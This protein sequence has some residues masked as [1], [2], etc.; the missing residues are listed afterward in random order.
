MKS[1]HA[2]EMTDL[3]EK[4]HKGEEDVKSLVKLIKEMEASKFTPAKG[5]NHR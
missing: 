4:L 1:S 3:R 5:E 2:T